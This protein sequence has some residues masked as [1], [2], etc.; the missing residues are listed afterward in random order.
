[1]NSEMSTP[2]TLSS[3]LRSPRHVAHGEGTHGVGSTLCASGVLAQRPTQL[4]ARPGQPPAR[5]GAPAYGAPAGAYVA[6]YTYSSTPAEGALNGMGNVISSKGSYNLS[7]SEAAINMTQAQSNELRNHMQ[8]ED[9]YFQ[10]R[11]SNEAYR[12]AERGPRPTEEQLARIARSGAPKPLSPSEVDTV[13]GAVNWPVVLQQDSFVAD[14][15]T[16]EQLSANKAAHGSLGF[17]DQMAAR[18]TIESMLAELKSQVRDVPSQDYIASK[19]FL[20][21]MIYALAHTGLS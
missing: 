5:Q 10:M 2:L 17:S 8:Y 15:T 18:K 3:P 6:P 20:E 13:S 9:T 1:M 21:S 12:E 19:H 7:T 4:P 11:E 16:L 14:R